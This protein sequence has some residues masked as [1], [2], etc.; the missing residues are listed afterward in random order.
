MEATA[1]MM[2]LA[3]RTALFLPRRLPRVLCV[4]FLSYPRFMCPTLPHN[5]LVLISYEPREQSS[6]LTVGIKSI[7]FRSKTGP[8]E[9]YWILQN[10]PIFRLINR[11][12]KLRK[13]R[14]TEQA[15][16]AWED[17]RLANSRSDCVEAFLPELYG[18]T[19]IMCRYA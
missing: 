4:R 18:G 13:Q 11:Q 6:F 3:K 15:V 16:F 12:A 2:P 7:L 17:L 1:T 14:V 8:R 19:N 10:H 5:P 9:S